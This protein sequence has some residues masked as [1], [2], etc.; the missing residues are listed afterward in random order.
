MDVEKLHRLERERG[1]TVVLYQ[2][3]LVS[4]SC[5]LRLVNI[6]YDEYHKY[7]FSLS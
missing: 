1:K 7:R 5:I 6:E 2:E 3:R 4:F